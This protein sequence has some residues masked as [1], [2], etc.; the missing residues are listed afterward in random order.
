MIH[1]TIDQII[2]QWDCIELGCY[3]SEYMLFY[4]WILYLPPIHNLLVPGVTLSNLWCVG[5]HEIDACEECAMIDKID[6]VDM[7]R[8]WRIARVG[9]PCPRCDK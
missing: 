4:Y 2:F 8:Y 3:C 9:T 6:G 5:N 1:V 7:T